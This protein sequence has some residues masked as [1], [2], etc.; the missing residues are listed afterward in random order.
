MCLVYCVA[1]INRAPHSRLNDISFSA[2]AMGLLAAIVGFAGSFTVVLQGFRSAGASEAEAASALMALTVGMGVSGIMLA[3]R[4]RM[5][6]GVAWSTPG[7]ALLIS[8]GAAVSYTHLTLPTTP[9][10]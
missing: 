2:I 5:P 3:W 10:V 1:V 6:I 8:S 4:Y 7:S 9:Y